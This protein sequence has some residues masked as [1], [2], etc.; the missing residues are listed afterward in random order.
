MSVGASRPSRRAV[1]V[2]RHT[3]RHLHPRARTAAAP[4]YKVDIPWLGRLGYGDMNG[5]PIARIG[6]ACGKRGIEMLKV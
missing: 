2:V 5:K 1:T 3:P 4:W 6:N